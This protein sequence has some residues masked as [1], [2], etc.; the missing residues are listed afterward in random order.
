MSEWWEYENLK[1][2]TKGQ[3]WHE[4]SHQGDAPDDNVDFH[5]DLGCGIISKARLGIDRNGK[6]DIFM[7]LET[8][9]IY[10]ESV[11]EHF[12][13]YRTF[14]YKED[15]VLP[16]PNNSVHSIISH[17]FFEHLSSDAFIK[18]IDDCY[19]VLAPGH[20][21]RIIV[22]AFPSFNAFEATD[23]KMLLSENSF[24]DFMGLEGHEHW[25]ESFATPYA[26]ARFNIRNGITTPPN[27]FRVALDENGQPGFWMNNEFIGDTINSDQMMPPGREL[28]ITLEK[29]KA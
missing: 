7:N 3:G 2:V 14:G 29:R 26:K 25:H 9:E 28:R 1:P 16:F 20:I 12:E 6:A 10:D 21:L 23:H 8:G 19:R 18:L 15:W 24:A 22:P 27:Q 17:H 13:K 11:L 5:L 4:A